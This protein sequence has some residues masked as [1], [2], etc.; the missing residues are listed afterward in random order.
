M[1]A[2]R[3]K[4]REYREAGVLVCWLIDPIARVAQVLDD[5]IGAEPLPAGGAL[6]T[7]HLPGLE[8]PLKELFAVL[9]G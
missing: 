6:S 7:K 2:Q 5:D 8:I 4:C 1:A 3:R 9:D